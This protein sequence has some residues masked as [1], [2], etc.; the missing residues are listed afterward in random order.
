MKTIQSY[1][2]RHPNWIDTDEELKPEKPS[3]KS[4]FIRSGLSFKWAFL[5]VFVFHLALVSGIYTISQLKP[6]AGKSTPTT[7]TNN[8]ANNGPKSDALARNKWPQAESKFDP[9]TLPP[10]PKKIAS[11]PET[12]KPEAHT[13]AVAKVASPQTPVSHATPNPTIASTKLPPKTSP[14]VK[15]EPTALKEKFL[16][17]KNTPPP[18][19]DENPNRET[20]PTASSVNPLATPNSEIPAPKNTVASVPAPKLD[21]PKYTP[22]APS[23]Y[24]LSAGDNLYAVSRRFQVSYN[25]LMDVNGLTDPRQL[26][27]GQKLKLPERKADSTCSL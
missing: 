13:P 6:K 9:K 22:P 8:P 14:A 17:T 11:R 1:P 20:M 2:T 19:R 5:I 16:A 10:A 15:S 23:E 18:S 26:R 27:V 4:R 21:A 24:T 12:K 25:D 7:A 3:W